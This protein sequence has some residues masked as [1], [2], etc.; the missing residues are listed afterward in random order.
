MAYFEGNAVFIRGA[1]KSINTTSSLTSTTGYLTIKV[2]NCTFQKNYG[3]NI[4]RG[5][6]LVI[7][8]M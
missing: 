6:A 4:A 7:D 3:L 1:Q 5:G 2:D 8:G